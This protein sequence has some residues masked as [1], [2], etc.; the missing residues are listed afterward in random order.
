MAVKVPAN[1]VVDLRLRCRV[2]VLELVH[3]LELDDVQTVGK[4]AV[5]L[6]LEEMFGLVRGDV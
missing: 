3:R 1:K 4:D 6:A 5:G 2:Q